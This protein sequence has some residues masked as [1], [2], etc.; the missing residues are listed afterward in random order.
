[1]FLNGT[2]NRHG[3]VVDQSPTFTAVQQRSH[4]ILDDFAGVAAIGLILPPNEFDA[5]SDQRRKMGRWR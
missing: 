3:S 2:S 5:G 1:V 4:S